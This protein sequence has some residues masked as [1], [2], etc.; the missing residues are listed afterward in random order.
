[1][2]DGSFDGSRPATPK[3]VAMIGGG[4][5]ALALSE[6][7]CRAGLL[8]ASEIIVYDPHPAARERLAGRVPGI[9]FASGG[10][11]A[12]RA[13]KLIFLAVKPQQ[14]Q[15]ACVEISP[16]LAADSVVVSIVAGLSTATLAG[17]LGTQKIVRVMPNTPSLVGRG[18]E[19]L[20]SWKSF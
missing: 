1:M 18:A 20:V 3:S 10:A 5:M 14:A 7:F 2:T 15:G 17:F 8:Q 16:G 4:Q 6:G 12:V 13:A 19:F 11:E 9:C